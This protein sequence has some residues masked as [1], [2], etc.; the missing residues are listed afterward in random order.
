MTENNTTSTVNKILCQC[1]RC[2]E[3][4]NYNE[5]NHKDEK[6]TIGHCPN[7]EGSYTTIKSSNSRIDR[8]LYE[9]SNR[10]N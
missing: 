3:V 1:N 6:D 9:L 2:G 7:C 8:Y 5:R 4:F 10:F